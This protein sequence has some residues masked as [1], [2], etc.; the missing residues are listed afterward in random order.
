MPWYPGDFLRDT[1]HLNAEEDGAYRRLIDA[2]WLRGGILVA[3]D[4]RFASITKLSLK[5]WLAIKATIAE[6]FIIADDGWHHKRVSQELAKAVDMT[7]ER[8]E[9]GKRGA[10]ARWGHRQKDDNTIAQPL[11]SASQTDGPSPSPSP[12]E[13]KNPPKAPRKRVACL[14]ADQ[15]KIFDEWYAV[16]PLHK[17]RLTAERSFLSALARASPAELLAGAARYRGE[18]AGK[19]QRYIAHPASWLNAGRWKDELSHG[20]GASNGTVHD[21]SQRRRPTSP[22]RPED[23][24][25]AGTG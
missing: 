11:A 7:T 6:F 21:L 17:A 23:L 8:S 3:N 12:E 19:E 4:E 24:V 5:R 22:P 10:A 18:C 16:Y 2:C 1:M 20:G 14:N 9:A 15:L 25:D 13:R